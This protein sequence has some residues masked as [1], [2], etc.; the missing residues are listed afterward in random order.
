MPFDAVSSGPPTGAFPA[1]GQTVTQY[2]DKNTSATWTNAGNGF[3]PQPSSAY[4]ANVF[5][6]T[7]AQATLLT[8]TA[9]VTGLYQIILF[10]AQ[11]TA[12]GTTTGAGTVAYTD[13]DSSAAIAAFPILTGTALAS[14]GA[15]QS[16]VVTIN[17]KAG[18]AITVSTAVVTGGGGAVNLKA[19]AVYVG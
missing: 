13:A 2:F 11:A 3:I 1:G 4:V 7:A 16:A 8:F 17:A 18:T 10:V 14:Q 15:A 6:A 5:A 19:R 9:P 12:T